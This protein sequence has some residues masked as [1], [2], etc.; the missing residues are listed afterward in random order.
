MRTKHQQRGL[1]FFGLLFVGIILAFAGV[2]VAQVVPTYI[3][4][5]AVQ[6]ATDKAAASGSTVSEI[7]AAFDRTAQIDDIRTISGRDLEIT[8]QGDRVVVSFDYS[9]EIHL[10]GPAYLVMKYQGRSK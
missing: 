2:V 6:K 3:E 5:M 9:R 8:K 1:T 4:Y 10:F 7:R